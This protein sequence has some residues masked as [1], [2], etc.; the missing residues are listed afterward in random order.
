MFNM[1]H[2]FIEVTV[3]VPEKYK[4]LE[5]E[6]QELVQKKCDEAAAEIDRLL[7]AYDG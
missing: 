4:L 6:I 2:P 7:R 5:A 3:V 1:T